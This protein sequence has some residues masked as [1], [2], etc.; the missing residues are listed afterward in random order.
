MVI[1]LRV[2]S[3]AFARNYSRPVQ[4]WTTLVVVVG[5]DRGGE[6]A[7]V[8]CMESEI[9]TVSNNVFWGGKTPPFGQVLAWSCV[10]WV[11]EILAHLTFLNRQDNAG[12]IFIA[13]PPPSSGYFGL[14]FNSEDDG[15][16]NFHH[17]EDLKSH[18][19]PVDFYN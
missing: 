10:F 19:Q 12:N 15:D 4:E 2:R 1:C 11:S 6:G 18:T 3:S 7:G 14:C 9:L 17:L 13:G 16:M 5:W 8:V